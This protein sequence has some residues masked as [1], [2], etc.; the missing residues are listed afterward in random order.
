MDSV[1]QIFELHPHYGY[2]VASILMAICV[3]GYILDW[4]LLVE[5]GGGYFNIAYWIE[6]FGRKTV[7]I[8][9]G[10]T[11]AIASITTM[12]MFLYYHNQ[13]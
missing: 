4:D 9:L 3:I 10:I 5:P 13:Q 8:F 7:R 6:V 1:K 2:F 12:L 11:T